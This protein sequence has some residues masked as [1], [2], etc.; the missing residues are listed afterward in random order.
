VTAERSRVSSTGRVSPTRTSDGSAVA[1]RSSPT[2]SKH[3]WSSPS[4]LERPGRHEDYRGDVSGITLAIDIGGTGIKGAL[5]GPD[6]EMRSDRVKVKTP[7]PMP[8]EHLVEVLERFAQRLGGFDQVAVGFPGVVREG[9][10]LSAPHFESERGLG[11]PVSASLVRRWSGFDLA[12]QLRRTLDR[13]TRVVNDAEMQG[14]GVISR[15]GLEVVVTL[16]TGFGFSVFDRGVPAPHMELGSMPLLKGKTLDEELGNRGRKR[17]GDDA[18]SA[19]VRETVE[20][21]DTLVNFDHCYLGGGNARTVTRDGFGQL[22]RRVT[23]V[24]NIAGI[25]GGRFLFE[26]R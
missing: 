3:L 10:I 4:D 11:N 25:L 6:G 13:P 26:D 8:P 24:G 19:K 7:Y 20:L 23:V 15:R 12:E 21:I 16:G 1:E 18:W 14:L 9:R 22:L 5:L 17:L 2:T